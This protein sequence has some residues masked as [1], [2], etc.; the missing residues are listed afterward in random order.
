MNR[1]WARLLGRGLVEPLDVMQN[2]AW[3]PDL[4][5]WLAEDLVAHG[6]NLK[7]TMELILTS[8][9]YQLPAVSLPEKLDPA[10][11]FQGPGIRRLTAEQFR[12]ALGSVTGVW[13]DK[14]EGG[15]DALLV[16]PGVLRPLPAEAFW[17][18]SDPHGATAVAP[19][20]TW[21]RRA[22]VLDA[23]PPEAT[24]FVHVDDSLRV[25][26]NGGRVRGADA[27]DSSHPGVYDL[28]ASLKSGT[29]VVILEAVNEGDE[30]NPAGVLAYLKLRTGPGETGRALDIASDA[31]WLATTNRMDPAKE[32][33]A[34]VVWTPASILGPPGLEHWKVG[35][36]LALSV[37]GARVYGQVR[38]SLT[39]ADPLALALGR[40]N[41]EQVTTVRQSTPT[42]I[43]ALEL[44]NGETLA[45]LLQ[46][47]AEQLVAKNADGRALAERVFAQALSRPPTARE[48]ALAVEL[49]GAQPRPEGVED[50]L[51][52]VTMLPE[53]QLTY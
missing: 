41:R 10:F 2:E 17:I 19:G 20:T 30:P 3:N 18:W 45:R 32:P 1:L 37:A 36:S 29:N 14:P 12:D 13:Q 28:R 8:R 26:V 49:V 50:L 25:F 39:G 46:R 27:P 22:L 52:S 15:L 11:V 35:D 6:W 47:G 40:P 42:T 23:V 48:L 21:F 16:E 34:G 53:F 4:L 7:R 38:A 31:T 24:L 33:S 43:Q 51:W 44:T 9:A 5:D